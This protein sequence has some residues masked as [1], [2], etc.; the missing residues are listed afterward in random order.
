MDLVEWGCTVKRKTILILTRLIAYFI[1]TT[2]CS[3]TGNIQNP[4]PTPSITLISTQDGGLISGI[5]CGP[6]CFWGIT[7][8]I[9]NI[10]DVIDELDS[11][12]LLTRCQ[13]SNKLSQEEGYSITC[14]PSLLFHSDFD[15]SVIETVSFIPT[16]EVSVGD[17]IDRHGQPICAVLLPG[18]VPEHPTTELMLLYTNPPIKLSL[19]DQSGVTFMVEASTLV[20]TVVYSIEIGM[21]CY[22][23][24]GVDWH[25]FGEYT[26]QME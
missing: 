6:P 5:P 25:G 8:G 9:S 22:S 7:P 21:D 23:H 19:P 20:Q 16:T 13:S 12:N 18:G 17:V 10:E 26:P 3:Y 15:D 14:W 24:G 1:I 11:R 2:G 4:T